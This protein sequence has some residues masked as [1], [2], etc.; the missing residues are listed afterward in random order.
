[1]NF[2]KSAVEQALDTNTPP[3]QQQQQ[4]VAAGNG[5]SSPVLC[6]TSHNPLPPGVP[7]PVSASSKVPHFCVR[8]CVNPTDT[9]IV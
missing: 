2:L 7:F 6:P 8:A 9:S 1:M 3:P 4:S 5:T